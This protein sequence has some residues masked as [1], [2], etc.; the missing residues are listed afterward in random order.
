MEQRLDPK[1]AKSGAV[2]WIDYIDPRA[3]LHDL[4]E[5]GSAIAR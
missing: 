1:R 4:A 5:P 3:E 2:A